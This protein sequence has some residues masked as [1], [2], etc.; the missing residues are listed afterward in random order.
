MVKTYDQSKEISGKIEISQEVIEV[1]A[2]KA[3]HDVPGVYSTQTSFSNEVFNYF[4]N[5]EFR[6]GVHL[7]KTKEGQL[8]LDI[9]VK[10]EYGSK[11]NEVALAIQQNVRDQIFNMTNVLISE[12]NVHI[13]GVVPVRTELK[14]VLTHEGESK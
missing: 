13:V 1:I 14:D 10:L 6:A 7:T 11:V 12:I 9:F 4:N 8:V 2:G 3:T 5:K